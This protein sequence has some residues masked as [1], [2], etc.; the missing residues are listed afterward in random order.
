MLAGVLLGQEIIVE[1]LP[2]DPS[3]EAAHRIVPVHP[4]GPVG[5]VGVLGLA[6]LAVQISLAGLFG[7]LLLLAAFP[8]QLG[9]SDLVVTPGFAHRSA[10]IKPS[11]R[12][13][14][15]PPRRP[16][17]GVRGAPRQARSGRGMRHARRRPP[18]GGW[19]GAGAV[20][21]RNRL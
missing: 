11:R 3:E 18:C 7:R 9:L 2:P 6:A 4:H 12:L 15:R 14:G 1:I 10:P 20:D 5:V 21:P 16:I 17:L 13:D 8:V 19:V